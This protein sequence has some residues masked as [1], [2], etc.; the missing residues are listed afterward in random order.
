MRLNL[1]LGPGRNLVEKWKLATPGM[2]HFKEE[3]H[4]KRILRESSFLSLLSGKQ[5]QALILS[6]RIDHA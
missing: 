5:V 4:E 1:L 6:L 3:L 2:D